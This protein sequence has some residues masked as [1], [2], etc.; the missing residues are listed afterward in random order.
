MV[1]IQDG[2]KK[3]IALSILVITKC[4]HSGIAFIPVYY[5]V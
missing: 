1:W 3:V 5:E 4:V 2:K